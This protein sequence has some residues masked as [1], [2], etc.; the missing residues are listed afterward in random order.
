MPQNVVPSVDVTVDVDF[1]IWML[2]R[3]PGFV[4][5]LTPD[6]YATPELAYAIDPTGIVDVVDTGQLG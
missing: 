5:R 1:W 4:R 6:P 2:K 3:D